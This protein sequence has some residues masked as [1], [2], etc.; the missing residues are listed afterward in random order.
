MYSSPL[1]LYPV[2]FTHI[3]TYIQIF[4]KDFSY[5][6]VLDVSFSE[7]FELTDADL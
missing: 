2:Q 6:G 3:H 7:V 5:K 4:S 1:L